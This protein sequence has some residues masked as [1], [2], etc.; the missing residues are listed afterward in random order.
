MNYKTKIISI[1][2]IVILVGV[3]LT[4]VIKPP[5]TGSIVLTDEN[6]IGIPSPRVINFN[7][8]KR[9]IESTRQIEVIAFVKNY[10]EN[11]KV[12][13]TAGIYAEGTEFNDSKSRTIYMNKGQTNEETFYFN[14]DEYSNVKCF[15]KAF[16]SSE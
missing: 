9:N 16:A 10:G 6:S 1:I 12:T 14:L 11:G 8:E 4:L 15:A 7:C 2:F 13:I 5:R 3:L